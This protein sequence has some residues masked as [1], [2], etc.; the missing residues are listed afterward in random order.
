VQK[1]IDSYF[2]FETK[3]NASKQSKRIKT[4]IAS[5][6]RK[7]SSNVE[8]KDPNVANL[9]SNSQKDANTELLQL[10]DDDSKEIPDLNHKK[11]KMTKPK[12]TARR[13]TTRKPK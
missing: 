4:A 3:I 2:N 8:R 6:K 9:G 7:N 1:T 13:K 10:S 12:T 5:F 11:L